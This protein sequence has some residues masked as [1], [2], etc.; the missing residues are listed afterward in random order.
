MEAKA[1][2]APSAP[3]EFLNR[4]E[5]AHRK[6]YGI[7]VTLSWL[8]SSNTLEISYL[9]EGD[10]DAFVATVPNDKGM[11]AF[12]HPNGFRPVVEDGV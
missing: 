3:P 9:D 6:G 7:E 11:E 12:R 2:I 5:L 4:R 10:N 8:I 1:P